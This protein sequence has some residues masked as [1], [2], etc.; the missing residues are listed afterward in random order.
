MVQPQRF[1]C[2]DLTFASIQVAIVKARDALLKAH[3]S[4]SGRNGMLQMSELL[5]YESGSFGGISESLKL[6]C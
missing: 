4:H 6:T 1:G 5:G 2:M 3:L